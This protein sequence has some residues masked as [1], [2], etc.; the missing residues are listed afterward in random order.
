[1][2]PEPFERHQDTS[3]RRGRRPST[4]RAELERTAFELFG[5][6]GYDATTVDDIAAAAGIGRRTFFR[7]FDSKN[8]VV[9]G[10]F[11]EHLEFM[12]VR[13]AQCPPAQPLM[14]AIRDVVVDFNRFDLAEVPWHR[15]RMELILRVP[16][17]QAHA[18]LRYGDWRAVVAEFVA[19]RLGVPQHGLVPQSVAYAALGVSLAAYEHWLACPD[20]ELSDILNGAMT[21]LAAGFGSLDAAPGVTG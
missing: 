9:W 12:R 19:D 14:D 8:D 4:S 5:A 18:T 15:R 6:H 10:S 17:L 11:S 13:F 20:A 21:D 3:L 16:A 1:M 7:Y 2:D